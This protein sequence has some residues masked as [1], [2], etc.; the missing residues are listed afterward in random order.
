MITHLALASTLVLS[1][2]AAPSSQHGHHAAPAAE[3]APAPT[4][5]TPEAVQQLL[6]GEGM[7]LA[8]PAE[9]NEYPGPKHVLEL[10]TELAITPEQEAKVLAIRKD[11]LE[12]AKAIG[13]EIVE[14]ERELDAAFRSGRL[15][16]ADL[17]TRVQ[18]I[19]RLQGDLRNAH[20]QAHLQTKP[21]LTPAQVAQYY[22]RRK[23]H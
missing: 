2:A 4:G 14:A 1:L 11:V 16:P 12:R 21:L 19:A 10:K 5:L 8:R 6:H 20:L 23:A 7:G 18:A 13:R 15:S 3:G 9:M 22:A 17:S